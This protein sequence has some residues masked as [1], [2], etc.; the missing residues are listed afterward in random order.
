[1]S[2]ILF[3]G[4]FLNAPSSGVQRVALELILASARLLP[5]RETGDYAI[6]APCN[7]K[8]LPDLKKIRLLE[9]G[10]LGGVLKNIPWEQITLP[11]AAR[12][13]ILINLCNSGPLLHGHSVIM[14]H[15]AQV[16]LSP[17]SYS[18]GFRAWYKLTQP[19]LGRFAR[20]V[21]TVSEYSRTQLAR[22]GVAPLDKIEVIHNGC[23]HIL[24]IAPDD[25][26]PARAG[27]EAGGYVVALANTQVHKNI[28]V[29]LKAFALETLRDVNLVLFGAHSKDDFEA[30]GHVVPDN[31]KFLGRVSDEQL[32]GLMRQAGAF[33][34]P[35][36]TEG[37]G[38]PP[39]EAMALGCPVII[40][41]CGALTEVCGEAAL[42]ADPHSP[43][44]WAEAVRQLLDDPQHAARL[45]ARGKEWSRQFTW[46][47]AA[48]N[49]WA[50]LDETYPLRIKS[51]V[52]PQAKGEAIKVPGGV[53]A[54]HSPPPPH[55]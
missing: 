6:V 48:R 32:A 15:D 16:Y 10:F 19:L 5:E 54:S 13:S 30:M 18:K 24:N 4:K 35:S 52:P 29:L 2:E 50:I 22:F 26:Y 47:R 39:L 27:L 42:Q 12:K 40:A 7:D 34:C 53:M 31:V 49:L 1:M 45:S 20:K 17:E 46:E 44:A 38:L 8:P 28:S 37:F 23:D 21:L 9:A 51:P 41:P 14:I 25:D 55:E 43:Q 3:N 33:A 36:L 11:W